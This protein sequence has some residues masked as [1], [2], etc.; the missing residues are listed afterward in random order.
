MRKAICFL[1]ALVLLFCSGC[2][3]KGP[4]EADTA[5]S[6][7]PM[8]ISVPAEEP[9]IESTPEPEADPEPAPEPEPTPEPAPSREP[10]GSPEPEVTA[11]PIPEPEPETEPTPEPETE[12]IPESDPVP[13][14]EPEPEPAPESSSRQETGDSNTTPDGADYVLNTNSKKFHYPHCSS[15][16]DMKESNKAFFRG[17][18][19]EAIALGYD[20]CGRCKP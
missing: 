2:G 16:E 11:E 8:L 7:N 5:E 14:S 18:R 1:C 9:E 17:T 4:A 12:H 13:E 19:D 15:V 10:I 6:S 3:T 20:P